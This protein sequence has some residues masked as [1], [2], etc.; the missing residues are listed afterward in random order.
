MAMRHILHP[1]ELRSP[2]WERQ[3]YEN[4]IWYSRFISYHALPPS[5]RSVLRVYNDERESRGRG[6]A[7]FSPGGWTSRSTKFKWRDRALAW[8]LQEV[9]DRKIKMAEDAEAWDRHRGQ[10]LLTM[11]GKLTRRLDALDP[12]EVAAKDLIPHFLSAVKAIEAWFGLTPAGKVEVSG[13][14]GGPVQVVDIDQRRAVLKEI[15]EYKVAHPELFQTG[16][17]SDA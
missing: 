11:Y 8:D 15:E 10:A 4:A 3:D 12:N 6:K 1:K 2:I 13:P 14:G 16:G 9:E 7:K 17:D 5:Q